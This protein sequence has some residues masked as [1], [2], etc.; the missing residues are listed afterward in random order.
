LDRGIGGVDAQ[1]RPTKRV[2]AEEHGDDCT[3]L[4]A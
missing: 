4:R 3:L 2:E 1:E